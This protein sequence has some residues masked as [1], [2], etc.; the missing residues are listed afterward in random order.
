MK[1]ICR[2]ICY[3]MMLTIFVNS[4]GSVSALTYDGITLEESD[5]PAI[6]DFST[7]S[8]CSGHACFLQASAYEDGSFLIYTR[9]L[10]DSGASETISKT[11]YI[12]IYNANGEFVEEV[13]I[14]TPF[15]LAVE[16]LET[17]INIYFYNGIMT[18]DYITKEL[19]YY[20]LPDS[21]DVQYTILALREKTFTCGDWE[22]SYAKSPVMGYSKLIRSNENGEETLID[23]PGLKN[24]ANKL[25]IG[26]LIGITA[27][28]AG[29]L[30]IVMKKKKKKPVF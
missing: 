18:Y 13:S 28:A 19:H 9:N 26:Q 14:A 21:V 24:I 27:F 17:A 23:L 15:D 5:M 4:I 16:K 25:R 3:L 2:I 6:M 12:D 11:A 1:T 22:Y 29:V 10:A 20:D 8:A 7:R 30:F